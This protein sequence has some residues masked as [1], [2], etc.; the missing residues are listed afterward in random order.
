[1]RKQI[2]AVLLALAA[3]L[4]AVGTAGAANSDGPSNGGFETG[5]FKAW[6]ALDG[7]A[8]EWSVYSGSSSFFPAPAEGNFAVSAVQ[9][10]PTVM[11]LTQKF[12]LKQSKPA[13]LSFWLGYEM[14]FIIC[15]ICGAPTGNDAPSTF[16][17]KIPV[18][19]KPSPKDDLDLSCDQELRVDVLKS[20]A[21]PST[22][23]DRDILT[24]LFTSDFVGPSLDWTYLTYDLTGFAGRNIKLRFLISASVGP[25]FATIDGVNLS[26]KVA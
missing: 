16:T 20:N 1:M 17:P 25:I 8:G 13:F 6:N 26:H 18:C 21:D 22:T 7:A 10:E 11:T 4:I 2:C 15:P 12:R 5:T 24:T 14:E 3:A 23:S 19:L 9:F